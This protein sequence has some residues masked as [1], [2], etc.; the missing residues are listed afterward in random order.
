VHAK[1][2]LSE[3]GNGHAN[4]A[5]NAPARDV[6]CGVAAARMR[7]HLAI[8][9]DLKPLA[10]KRDFRRPVGKWGTFY[11]PISLPRADGGNAPWS[12]LCPT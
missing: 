1:G 9:Q 2:R 3:M 8:F 5:P 12:I 11:T 7:T 4:R 10:L 6:R